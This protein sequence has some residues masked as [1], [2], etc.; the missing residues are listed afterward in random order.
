[1]NAVTRASGGRAS[2]GRATGALD[3]EAADLET[4]VAL[5]QQRYE[6]LE[7]RLEALEATLSQLLWTV[8][9]GFGSVLAVMLGAILAGGA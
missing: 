3:K 6:S 1:M 8:A 7:R 2:G 9:G 5:C 4:H